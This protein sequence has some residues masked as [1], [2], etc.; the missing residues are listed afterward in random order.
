[1]SAGAAQKAKKGDASPPSKTEQKAALANLD[2]TLRTLKEQSD[3]INAALKKLDDLV[4][5]LDASHKKWLADID[6]IEKGVK[7][8]GDN[9][10]TANTLL[11]VAVGI[12]GFA[13]NAFTVEK[14]FQDKAKN[15]P[16][17]IEKLK[18]LED[19]TLPA[20]MEHL[21]GPLSPA[22]SGV[23][24][25]LATSKKSDSSFWST[26]GTAA[27]WF[28]K[29]TSPS[30]WAKFFT[31]VDEDLI[32]ARRQI[33]DEFG[34]MKGNILRRQGALREEAKSLRQYYSEFEKASKKAK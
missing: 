24:T 13:K 16:G 27:D 1:M 5:D 9:A 3:Q 7:K 18:K 22:F 2:A 17:A 8:A 32:E 15:I 30:G 23:T 33:D 12:A 19:G 21:F 28:G 31:G 34:K 29:V 20:V 26:I 4:S 14:L 25:L 11:N 6:K 10:D